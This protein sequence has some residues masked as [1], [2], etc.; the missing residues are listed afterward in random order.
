LSAVVLILA[1]AS[2]AQAR[3]VG[4]G[5]SLFERAQFEQAQRIFE[6]VLASEALSR[7][8]AI[9]AHSHLGAIHQILGDADASTAHAAAAIALDP[10]VEPPN[11]APGFEPVLAAARRE[12]GQMAA[13]RIEAPDAL[14]ANRDTRIVAILDPAPARLVQTIR[15]NCSV[16]RERLQ[17]ESELPSAE[18]TV[19]PLESASTAH[20]ESEAVTEGGARLFSASEDLDVFIPGSNT[21]LWVAIGGGAALVLSAVIIAVAVS[22]SGGDDAQIVGEPTIVGWP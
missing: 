4:R 20:C 6:E 11:G 1:V 5:V 21:W 17:V 8:D 3:D 19:T 13:L 12:Q 14:P 16:G 7:Q 15:L 10:S 2:P 9:T 22:S 18:I